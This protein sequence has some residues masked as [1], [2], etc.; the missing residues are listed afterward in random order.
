MKKLIAVGFIA[1]CVLFLT[2]EYRGSSEKIERA[3]ANEKEM[4]GRENGTQIEQATHLFEKVIVLNEEQPIYIKDN[5][6]TE[7]GVGH[8]N[9]SFAIVGED[10][11][12]YE[13][14]FGKISAF[15]KKGSATVEKRSL[16]TLVNTEITNSIKTTEQTKV[17]EEKNLTSS[18]LLHLSQG[19]RYPIVGEVDEWFVIKVGER[20]GYIHKSSIEIDEGIP[21]LVYHHI[22][23]KEDMVTNASTVSVQSFEQQMAFL[24]EEQFTTISTTQLY[25]YLEGRQ[26]LPINSV[27]L[28]FDDGLLSTKVYAYPILKEHGFSAVQH[29][30]SSRTGRFE[31]EQVF[32][33]KG[34]LQ[35]FTAEEMQQMTDVFQYEAHTHNLHQFSNG[36]GIALEMSSADIAMDLQQ[37]VNMLKNATSLAYPFGHYD[38]DMIAA[39]KEV[40][41][42][43]G[44]T[45]NEGYAN[46]QQ[47][48]Y[49]VNRFGITEN[50]TFEQFTSFVKGVNWS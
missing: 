28:T 34:P 22:L 37:N 3:V 46:M 40:G 1:I 35:F 13:L 27:L 42:L 7:I 38:E 15:I 23:P 14:R 4:A 36:A 33:S 48:N 10:E 12:Y 9:T 44:F 47:S 45:T 50:K 11:L 43:I 2:I 26:I 31:G 49:E 5:T 16:Q 6:L 21:V 24:A 41:L 29:I 17:Y 25:D 8:P 19:F 39:M 30:I 20:A 32:D 18:V